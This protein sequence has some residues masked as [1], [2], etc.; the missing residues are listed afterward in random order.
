MVKTP[1]EYTRA[2]DLRNLGLKCRDCGDSHPV[3][4]V[5]II[6]G[7]FPL[8]TYCYKCL[9]NRCKATKRPAKTPPGYM[10]AIPM[11]MDWNLL[12]RLKV[13]LGLEKPSETVQF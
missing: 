10:C 8:G 12:S 9:L 6:N 3:Y 4:T 5:S 7:M 13:D 1:D 11:P 2:A